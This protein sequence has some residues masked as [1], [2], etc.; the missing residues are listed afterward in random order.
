MLWRPGHHNHLRQ[1]SPEQKAARRERR[2]AQ[3]K[4]HRAAHRELF[5]AKDKAY[6]AANRERLKAKDKAYCAANRERR[7]PVRKAHYA[8]N[9]ERTHASNNAWRKRNRERVRVYNDTWRKTKNPEKWA[10]LNRGAANRRRARMANVELEIFTHQEIWERDHGLCGICQ[11]PADPTN[12]HLD[13]I[14]PLAKQGSHTRA[15]VQV[16]HPRC[17]MKKWAHHAGPE[18]M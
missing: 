17:N 5:K 6:R 18:N 9:R 16:A 13:H 4:V 12:W 14:I 1:L 7:R 10:E 3:D 11:H 15:N 2:T 8:A